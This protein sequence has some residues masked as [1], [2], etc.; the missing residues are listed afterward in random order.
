MHDRVIFRRIA[1]C[2]TGLTIAA[3]YGINGAA[4]KDLGV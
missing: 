4:W 2:W 3:W 1:G